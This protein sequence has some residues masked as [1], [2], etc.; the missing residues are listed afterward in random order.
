MTQA[1]SD[2]LRTASGIQSRGAVDKLD[3]GVL[4]V[5]SLEHPKA[6]HLKPESWILSYFLIRKFDQS[7]KKFFTFDVLS[8]HIMVALMVL[9]SG[10]Q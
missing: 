8:L 1:H 6:S 10:S 7:R 2:W 3:K 4:C 5:Q 9:S